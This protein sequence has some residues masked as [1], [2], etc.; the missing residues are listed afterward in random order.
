MKKRR[1]FWSDIAG[2]IFLLLMMVASGFIIYH[3][4]ADTYSDSDEL[5]MEM[6]LTYVALCGAWAV[7]LIRALRVLPDRHA[8]GMRLVSAVADAIFIAGTSYMVFTAWRVLFVEPAGIIDYLSQTKIKYSLIF[9]LGF[10][11]VITL[12]SAIVLSVTNYRN[13]RQIETREA[14]EPE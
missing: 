3:L 8:D 12:W 14:G 2:F 5:M 6:Q 9:L 4:A 10:G 7:L 1:Y 13:E 11:T